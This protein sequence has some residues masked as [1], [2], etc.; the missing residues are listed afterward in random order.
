MRLLHSISH[1]PERAPDAPVAAMPG[2][3]DRLRGEPE[4]IRIV[5]VI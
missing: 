1:I 3:E 4:E 5:K 2:E